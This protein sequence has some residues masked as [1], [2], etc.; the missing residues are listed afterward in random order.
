MT[1]QHGECSH[2]TEEARGGKEEDSAYKTLGNANWSAA[3]ES[4]SVGGSG[5][6][7]GRRKLPG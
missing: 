5:W 1:L 2:Q 6:R 7:G 3:D 4:R